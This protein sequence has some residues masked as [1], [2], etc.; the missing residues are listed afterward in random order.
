[1]VTRKSGFPGIRHRCATMSE[2]TINGVRLHYE[3]QGDGFPLIF[4]H[5]FAG[6]GHSWKMQ[7]DF[8]Q[9]RYRVVTYN[10]RGYPPSEV[11]ADPS[12]YRQ[13]HAIEDLHGLLD[14]LGI[15]QAHV[16]ALSM[17]SSMALNF[18]V[19]YPRRARSLA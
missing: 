14:H 11:P 18:A 6:S 13:E 7:R 1:M 17:G 2:A 9:S 15:A 12:L 10:A 16:V 5:E 3:V 4:C 19:A 8:F